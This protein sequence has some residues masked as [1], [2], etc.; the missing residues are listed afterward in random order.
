[1]WQWKERLQM[2]EILPT[3]AGFEMEDGGQKARNVGSF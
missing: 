2:R 1:M 3:V